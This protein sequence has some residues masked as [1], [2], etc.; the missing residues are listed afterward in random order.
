MS[1]S[2]MDIGFYYLDI[3]STEY[4]AQQLRTINVCWINFFVFSWISRTIFLLIIIVKRH[5]LFSKFFKKYRARTNLFYNLPVY[6]PDVFLII[7]HSILAREYC[8]NFSLIA[9]WKQM[10]KK[11]LFPL[12]KKHTVMSITIW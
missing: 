10:K 1:F 11:S 4:V 12:E 2:E 6:S 3:F 7:Y 5:P 8:A 9:P